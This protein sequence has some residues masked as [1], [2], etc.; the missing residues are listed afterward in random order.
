[1]KILKRRN[2]DW[3]MEH[4]GVEA[5]YVVIENENQTFTVYEIGDYDLCG[6][7]VA[8]SQTKP[9]AE[10]NTLKHFNSKTP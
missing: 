7:L 8:A 4:N 5:P 2:G 6:E 10:N 9:R 3:C 1:M